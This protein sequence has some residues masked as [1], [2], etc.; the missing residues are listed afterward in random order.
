MSVKNQILCS[1]KTA[2]LNSR[3]KRL[4]NIVNEKVDQHRNRITSLIQNQITICAFTTE[5]GNF[6]TT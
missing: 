2:K 4:R 1:Q 3:K 5:I 6:F